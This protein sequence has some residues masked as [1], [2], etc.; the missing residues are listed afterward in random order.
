MSHLRQ[1][2][3]WKRAL[4]AF[5]LGSLGALAFASAANATHQTPI[6]ASPTR[7]SLVP[8]YA[9][10]TAP[11]QTHNLPL[12]FLSCS[13]SSTSPPTPRSPR[14][15]WGPS[16]I[17]FVRLVVCNVGAAGAFCNPPN[18]PA[19]NGVWA[20]PDIRITG[21][22]TDLRCTALAPPCPTPG[23]SPYNP[24]AAASHYTAFGTGSTAPTPPCFPLAPNPPG[25]TN[26]NCGVTTQD[27]TLTATIPGNAVGGA[28]R[29]TDHNNA[30]NPGTTVDSPF[31]VP[32]DC[33]PIAG[34]GSNCGVNTSA[35]ALV[36]GAVI[37]GVAAD[38]EVGQAMMLDNAQNPFAVQGIFTP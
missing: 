14:V 3:S 22:V 38:I 7:V 28:V 24:N 37:P 4:L 35:N 6:G 20:Q 23:T 12:G 32:V 33:T 31:P 18:P 34:A 19:P 13:P 8:A 36:G 25:T 17:G 9:P 1:S 26:N 2:A 11:D 16:S 10:C 15:I 5:A 27:A 29:I 30:T 21:N